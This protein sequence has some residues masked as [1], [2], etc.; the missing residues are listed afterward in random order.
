MTQQTVDPGRFSFDQS[1]QLL[2]LVVVVGGR[3]LVSGALLAGGLYLVQ[4]LPLP[5]A[6]D[7][8]LPLAIALAVVNIAKEP[9][10]TLRV[11]ARQARYCLAVLYRLPRPTRSGASGIGGDPAPGQGPLLAADAV[12]GDRFE[13]VV[14]AVGVAGGSEAGGSHG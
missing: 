12:G 2:L 6:V 10:G 14:A 13:P 1:L 9:E 5:T 8:Y 3:S 7:R 11:A 4:L